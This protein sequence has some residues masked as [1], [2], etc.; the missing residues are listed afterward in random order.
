MEKSQVTYMR[1]DIVSAHPGTVQLGAEI[2][3]CLNK[4]SPG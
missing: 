3:K 1:A 4:R 2:L